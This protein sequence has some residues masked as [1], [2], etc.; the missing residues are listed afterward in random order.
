VV[1]NDGRMRRSTKT[2]DEKEEPFL[3]IVYQHVQENLSIRVFRKDE[4]ICSDAARVDF[5]IAK[6]MACQENL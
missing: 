4:Q 6:L 1:G 2:I 5:F 3:K